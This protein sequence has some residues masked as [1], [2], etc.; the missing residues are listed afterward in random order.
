MY[1]LFVRATHDE[2]DPRRDPIILNYA[3]SVAAVM[4]LERSRPGH[5]ANWVHRSFGP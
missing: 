2:Y 1:L 3:R 4:Q 5:G